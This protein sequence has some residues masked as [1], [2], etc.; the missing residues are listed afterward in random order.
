MTTTG[1][2]SH[3]SWLL[4]DTVPVTDGHHAGEHSKLSVLEPLRV[5]GVGSPDAAGALPE[6]KCYQP[7]AKIA[8]KGL[9]EGPFPWL[10]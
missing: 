8:F 10:G 5:W 1:H 9:K 2:C 7:Q 4:F 3:G 6:S